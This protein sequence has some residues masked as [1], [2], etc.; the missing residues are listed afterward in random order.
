M[1]AVNESFLGNPK[2]LKVDGKK[3]VVLPPSVRSVIDA[4]A[5]TS[6]GLV[7]YQLYIPKEKAVK[8]Y[9]SPDYE[10]F[11]QTPEDPTIFFAERSSVDKNGRMRLHTKLESLEEVVLCPA[12]TSFDLYDPSDFPFKEYL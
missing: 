5:S 3:R 10:G 4:V 1:L 11:I 8:C 12:G 2:I 6:S 9:T 7:V